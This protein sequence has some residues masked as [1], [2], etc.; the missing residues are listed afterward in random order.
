MRVAFASNSSQIDPVDLVVDSLFLL[1]I[2]ISFASAYIDDDGT[3]V[4]DA[5][6]ITTKYL[7]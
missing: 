5:K 1:D 2:F 3:V 6:K 7:R 4:T